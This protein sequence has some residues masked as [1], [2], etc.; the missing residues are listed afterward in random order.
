MGQI[1]KPL[2]CRHKE[3]KRPMWHGKNRREKQFLKYARNT[4]I[5][6]LISNI[7][8]V[9]F[10]I[11]NTPLNRCPPYWFYYSKARLDSL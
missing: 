6:I 10:K 4:I 8:K 2:N 9:S 11:I 7:L 5:I 3:S 1:N